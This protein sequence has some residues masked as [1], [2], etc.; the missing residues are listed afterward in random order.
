MPN[1]LVATL[2]GSWQ[3]I[4]EILGYTNEKEVRIY[5][6]YD[7]FDSRKKNIESV[8]PMNEVWLVTTD[9]SV[10]HNNREKLME[11]SQC[12]PR[13]ALR[14]WM[15]EKVEDITSKESSEQMADLIYRLVLHAH[16]YSRKAQAARRAES[17]EIHLCLA[18]GRKTMSAELQ[19][20]GQF[21]GCH[22]MLHVIETR[23]IRNLRGLIESPRQLQQELPPEIF[24]A[25][26]P[27]F[28]L[29]KTPP[30]EIF[31]DLRSLQE[32]FP[33]ELPEPG[34]FLKVS[35]QS[36]LY[37]RVKNDARQASHLH[38]N[39]QRLIDKK[40]RS[41]FLRL[42]QLPTSKIQALKNEN[43]GCDSSKSEEDL[44]WIKRIPKAELHCHMG[45]ILTTAGM[46]KVATSLEEKVES[47]RKKDK[48]YDRFIQQFQNL[49]NQNCIETLS[50]GLESLPFPLSRF[51]T[52]TMQTP[53]DWG[54]SPAI[55]EPLLVAGFLIAFQNHPLLL[56]Q[57]LFGAYR[58]KENYR[59]IGFENYASLGDLQG[60]G[61]LQCRETIL[62]ALEE[63]GKYCKEE[64]IIYLELR[65]SPVKY[66][67][68]GLT[69]EEVVQIILDGLDK[70][71]HCDI[72]LIFIAS[73]HGKIDETRNHI[74]LT[75]KLLDSDERFQQ[76]FVGFDLAGDEKI[77][78]PAEL[79]EEFEPLM[80]EIV[81]I[82]IHAGE[83]T[84][85]QNI[86]EAIYE[87]SADRIGHGLT[88]VDDD[89]LIRRLRDRRIAIELCPSS[90]DQIVGFRD[91]TL[92]EDKYQNIY[93]LRGYLE[94]GL[95]VCLNTDNPGISRTTLSKE[96]LKAANMTDGGLSRWDVLN[97][98]RSSFQTAFCNYDDRLK[99]L[100]LSEEEIFNIIENI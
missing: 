36:D 61:L 64:N 58:N 19:Q 51:K 63:L 24:D 80:K 90:N 72:R 21:F 91:W 4:P 99:L 57:W 46:I 43:L 67:R 66:T 2:G 34:N 7:G 6:K 38:R 3:I 49:A 100:T 62:A 70:I 9:G 13:I 53:K 10:S 65:C 75:R 69:E 11:W 84:D 23:D 88:L 16:K 94:N 8:P 96:F 52:K 35:P 40:E 77:C 39:Y 60:S 86:W 81:K 47:A 15:T 98:I 29:G 1:I 97:M 95:K 71:E 55:K 22:S 73:R 31:R 30:N 82:T 48:I 28:L 33:L 42:Y 5:Q 93:P 83:G 85:V 59:A 87:L 25:F 12:V 37:A 27:I 79:R 68:G 41:N 17:G 26:L 44:Q 20:A 54:L 76:R 50:R 89:K 56:D 92:P 78:P 45:G 14:I 32:T 18:G 74:S